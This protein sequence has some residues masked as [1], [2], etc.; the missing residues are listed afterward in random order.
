MKFSA[1]S[2]SQ[3][4]AILI[5]GGTVVE[6]PPELYRSPERAGLEAERW[7]WILS[8]AGW[9]EIERPF[10]GRWQVGEREVRLVAAESESTT[11]DQ[12]W[13]CTFWTPEGSPEPEALIVDGLRQAREWATTFI[14]GIEPTRL[15]E[16]RWHVAATFGIGDRESYA[17]AHLAKVVL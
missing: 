11:L 5:T 3:M 12:P 10:D 1:A 6:Y 4:W 9:A 8:G 16:S 7:A 14:G 15:D 13:V 17:V 2:S